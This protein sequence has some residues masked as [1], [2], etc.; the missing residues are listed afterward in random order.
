MTLHW[1]RN[2]VSEKWKHSDKPIL[3]IKKNEI[4]KIKNKEY[5]AF[6]EICAVSIAE[7]A[8]SS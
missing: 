3:I 7:Y 6:K 8:T 5:D 2:I 1:F 4:D